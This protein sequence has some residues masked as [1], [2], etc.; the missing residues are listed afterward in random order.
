MSPHTRNLYR[1]H[2]APSPSMRIIVIVI[3]MVT[4]VTTTRI[5]QAKLKLLVVR[6]GLVLIFCMIAHLTEL[7]DVVM[8]A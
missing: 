5:E 6:E 2:F 1:Y 8:V 7:C 4:M 3:T